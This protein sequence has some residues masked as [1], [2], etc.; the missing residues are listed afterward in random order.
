MHET[1]KVDLNV[2]NSTAPSIEAK[3]LIGKVDDL[4]GCKIVDFASSCAW[5]CRYVFRTK[6]LVKSALKGGYLQCC[7]F[8]DAILLIIEWVRKCRVP[9]L[10]TMPDDPVSVLLKQCALK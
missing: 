7:V 5:T 8:I 2:A 1:D 3:N 4:L 10:V 9:P 6:L